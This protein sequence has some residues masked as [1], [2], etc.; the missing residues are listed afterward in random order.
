VVCA[1]AGAGKVLVDVLDEGRRTMA[2][3]GAARLQPPPEPGAR[4]P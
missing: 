1:V 3:N 2:S 4:V